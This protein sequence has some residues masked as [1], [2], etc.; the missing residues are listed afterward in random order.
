MYSIVLLTIISCLACLALTPLVRA[1]SHKYGV[2]DQPTDRKRHASPIPRTGGVAIAGAYLV[3]VGL[4]LLSPLNAADSVNLPFVLRLLPA[5][6]MVFAVG[7]VDDVVGLKASE[8]LPILGLAALLAYLNGVELTGVAGYSLPGWSSLLLTVLWLVA[9][10]NAFNLIDGVDGLATGVGLFATFTVLAAA[11]LQENA[12]LALATAPLVGALVAFLRYNFNPASIF[13]GDSGSL[14]IGFVLGCFAIIWSQKSAT[15]LGMTAPLM[16]LSVPLLDTGIAVVRRF[17]RRQPIF[18]PDRNHA[19][20][21]L[22]DRGLGPKKVVLL[23]YC[24]CGL[25]AAFALVQS[26]PHNRFHGLLLVFFCAAVVLAIRLVGYAEFDVAWK[27]LTS[28]TLRDMVQMRMAME[29]L[30][31]RVAAATTLEEY[32]TAMRE[33]TRELGLEPLRMLMG[34]RAFEGG[35]DNWSPAVF[36]GDP[37]AAQRSSDAGAPERTGDD[38]RRCAIRVPLPDSGYVNLGLPAGSTVRQALAVT[39]LVDLLQRSL[40]L[41]T[42]QPAVATREAARA[43]SAQGLTESTAKS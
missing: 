27:L 37:G 31:K 1:A 33:S 15:L 28:G 14:T 17:I 11:L 35:A 22:L 13:L 12:P 19:H 7:L 20:H 9:C 8:K 4:L 29:T 16:A 23:M 21:R 36:L 2:I 24:A 39:A 30:E 32:W 38:A 34:E 40:P 3:A 43:M 18:T 5:A 6:A 26:L 10:A 42:A 25:A 41:S